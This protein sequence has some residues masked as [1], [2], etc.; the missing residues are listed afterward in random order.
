M[1]MPWIAIVIVASK[2]RTS[3]QKRLALNPS[4]KATEPPARSIE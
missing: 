1:T 2:R 4:L 3:S